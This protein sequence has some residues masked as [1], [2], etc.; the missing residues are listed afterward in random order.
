[1]TLRAARLTRAEGSR[2]VLRADT[3]ND[4]FHPG[5]LMAAVEVLE[6]VAVPSRECRGGTR[7]AAPLYDFGMRAHA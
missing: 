6:A 5:T 7:A 1:M 2:V 4:N 3:F